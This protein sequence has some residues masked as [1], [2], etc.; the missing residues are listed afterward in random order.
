MEIF[1]SSDMTHLPQ[2]VISIKSKNGLNASSSNGSTPVIDF[3][4]GASLGFYLAEDVVLS[5]DFEYTSTSGIVYD[6]RPQNAGGLGNM[7]R[8]LD[9]YS[10][11]DG[12]LLESITD[13]HI[14]NSVLMTHN[15]G[16][17]MEI[18][19]GNF[20][21]MSITE[22]YTNDYQ[23]RTP[24]TEPNSYPATPTI[25]VAPA[26]QSQK[27][28]L[29]IRLS[30]LLNASQVIPVGALGGIRIRLQLNRPEIFTILNGRELNDEVVI[31]PETANVLFP[32][33][34]GNHNNTIVVDGGDDLQIANSDP[35]YGGLLLAE[36]I[37]TA[38]TDL[39]DLS[40]AYSGEA[41]LTFTNTS[42]Q[43]RVLTG[44][45]IT[46]FL[47]A[48]VSLSVPAEGS[49]VAPIPDD[50][51]GRTTSLIYLPQVGLYINN[52][53]D[54]SSCPFKVGQY[55]K[56]NDVEVSNPIDSIS[57]WEEGGIIL[58]LTD[59]SA[60]ASAPEG[61][62][63][64]SFIQSTDSIEYSLK[65][66]SLNVPII[67]PPPQYVKSLQEAIQS[68]EGMSMDMKSWAV[69]R[70]NIQKGQTLASLQIPLNVSRAKG[71]LSVPYIVNNGS[72]DSRYCCDNLDVLNL[73][74]YH[75]EYMGVRHPE[76]SIDCDKA[77]QG[78][79]SQELIVEQ[80]K[81]FEYSLE[82][83]NNLSGYSNLYRDKTFFLGRNL[84]VFNSVM[85]T[86]DANISL[87]LEATSDAG[88]VLVGTLSAVSLNVNTYCCSVFNI[89][90]RPE[91]V[92]LER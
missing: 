47:G 51:N 4:I 77:R 49:L 20:K 44:T 31:S 66:I 71:L 54:I 62:L 12:V 29:P 59:D 26:Y 65:N 53:L 38:L 36:A 73:T 13:Y 5:F 10:I 2:S 1:S 82:K 52:P 41:E 42:D 19:D 79:L 25:A 75:Y 63:V 64:K 58:T 30:H 15:N 45:F 50:S 11:Q 9:I 56:I 43:E 80:V 83:L 67:T 18:Q 86:R 14:L 35:R 32:Y 55:I 8:Q 46:S 76:R 3:E 74:K 27:I 90:M 16:S 60:I 70:S 92:L 7:I 81:A 23:F 37:N 87:S 33:E 85:D 84:G 6:L 22:S 24:Y 78:S 69:V 40:V 48:E 28:Q 68:A 57:A 91:G 88:G 17:D 34:I 39:E 21:K 61:G 89:R 72:F